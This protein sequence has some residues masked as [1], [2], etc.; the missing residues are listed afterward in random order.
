MV[1]GLFQGNLFGLV[2]VLSALCFLLFQRICSMDKGLVIFMR[3][4]LLVFFFGLL[5]KSTF[6]ISVRIKDNFL[7][8]KTLVK[9][10][11]RAKIQGGGVEERSNHHSEIESLVGLSN[12]KIPDSGRNKKHPGGGGNFNRRSQDGKG[13]SKH[14]QNSKTKRQNTK[15]MAQ[16][17]ETGNIPNHNSEITENLTNAF[18][19]L[20]RISEELSVPEKTDSQERIKFDPYSDPVLRVQQRLLEMRQCMGDYLLWFSVYDDSDFKRNYPK[21]IESSQV[22]EGKEGGHHN[23][24]FAQL[25]KEAGSNFMSQFF[26]WLARLIQR[27]FHIKASE[28]T[29]SR[30]KNEGQVR[31][32]V[33]SNGSHFGQS[34]ESKLRTHKDSK[35][36]KKNKKKKKKTKK[37]KADKSKN[38]SKSV[39]SRG[40]KSNSK[41]KSLSTAKSSK[42]TS[43]APLP[44]SSQA[45]PHWESLFTK[46]HLEI[47]LDLAL[48]LMLCA[49]LHK[50]TTLDSRD[51]FFSSRSKFNSRK[52]I[53]HMTTNK[54]TEYLKFNGFC[55]FS[56]IY[57]T[58][59]I[60]TGM[61]GASSP[62]SSNMLSIVYIF[63]GLLYLTTDSLIANPSRSRLLSKSFVF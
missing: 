20:K 5:F 24:S 46:M 33:L 4:F 11:C 2:L 50:K 27:V 3:I 57:L 47:F 10:L 63:L 37:R 15:N 17:S 9:N 8:R 35:S 18:K 41:H 36:K 43:G 44:G 6:F 55:Y 45:L 16:V 59:M 21:E 52:I 51:I 40:H 13:R 32:S 54:L 42:P 39:N 25:G 56:W 12:K 62:R 29:I 49:F 58:L 34:E 7:G 26:G 19:D 28:S 48:F 53:S 30:M 22:M 38:K 61:S 31:D 1:T 60:F 23:N 14:K